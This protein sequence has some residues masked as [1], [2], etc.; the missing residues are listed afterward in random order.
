M[1]GDWHEFANSDAVATALAGNVAGR[2]AEAIDAR[3]RA[4]L[5]VSGGTTPVRFFGELSR[6]AIGWDKV[7]VTLVD[8][9]FVPPSHER[10][11]ERLVRENLLVGRAA[12]ARFVGMY[13]DAG[14]VEEA[15]RCASTAVSGLM[16]ADV[17]VLGM[18]TDGH[19]ASLFPDAVGIAEMLRGPSPSRA[20]P[21]P[22]LPPE[23]GEE[24]PIAD[25]VLPVHAPSAGEAR[26][27][28][29][30]AAICK[31]RAVFLHIE[32]ARKRGVLKRAA[33]EK[34]PVAA[35]LAAVETPV[36]TYWAP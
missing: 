10:S 2:L 33:A 7:I 20:A 8:E 24:T 34:L 35:V 31:A 1:R 25:V 30:L 27:T 5:A 26:L 18:G 6:A 32:G 3:G 21:E 12:E 19:T 16:P 36:V 15:A 29:S 11:N 28:L 4:V 14:S 13:I 9:R 17:L 22:P 23:G